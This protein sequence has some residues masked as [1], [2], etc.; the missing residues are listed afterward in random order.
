MGEKCGTIRGDGIPWMVAVRCLFRRSKNTSAAVR[1][2][3]TQEAVM[4]A[5]DAK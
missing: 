4:T 2:T 5:K 3:Q 1:I